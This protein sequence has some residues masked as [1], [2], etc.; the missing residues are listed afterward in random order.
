MA[1][2][3]KQDKDIEKQNEQLEKIINKLTS[4]ETQV[5]EIKDENKHLTSIVNELKNDNTLLKDTL[6]EIK[7]D[8]KNLIKRVINLE[9]SDSEKNEQLV[10]L[11]SRVTQL[12]NQIDNH[13]QYSKIDNLIVTGLKVLRPFNATA[14][15]VNDQSQVKVDDE[16]KEEWSTNDKDIMAD[17]FIRFAKEKLDVVLN[18]HDISD[19]HTLPRDKDKMDTCIVR[20]SNRIARDKVIRN[21][22]KLK[23]TSN[24]SKKIYINEHLTKKNGEIA[25][26][27]RQMRKNGTILGTW[28]KSCKIF[29]KKLDE[30]VVR[31]DSLTDLRNL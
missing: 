10:D 25:R 24:S 17:N 26:E 9:K 8:N 28:T 29:V 2:K 13:E 3:N 15:L 20:F 23:T 19:M 30:R 5:E 31:V 14:L 12:E 27:A 21:R 11:N 4:L 7:E 6:N 16:G 1:G 22:T 18:R